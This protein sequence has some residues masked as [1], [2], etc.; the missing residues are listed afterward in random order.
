MPGGEEMILADSEGVVSRWD[1]AT[2]EELGEV[3]EAQDYRVTSLAVSNDGSAVVIA[4]EQGEQNAFY[5]AIEGTALG[6]DAMLVQL[7][8]EAP[9]MP[10]ALPD[11][12]DQRDPTA[13]ARGVDKEAATAVAFTADRRHVILGTSGGRV[14]AFDAA[15]G[16]PDNPVIAHQGKVIQVL[17]GHA[18]GL[19]LSTSGESA[20][21]LLPA[22][23]TQAVVVDAGTG[24]VVQTVL[25]DDV[26]AAAMLSMDEADVVLLTQAGGVHA[27][28]LAE[29][30]LVKLVR[31]KLTHELTP[32]EC[33]YY[34]IERGC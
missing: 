9:A 33:D 31:D 24:E 8:G 21:P 14:V 10:L 34:Q 16:E 28:P 25:S 22:G 19:V 3:L 5:A 2:G 26:L 13:S 11:D 7:D 6:P 12:A 17:A 29:E 15:T 4:F 32:A 23:V 27:L 30:D 1:V 20:D 18:G